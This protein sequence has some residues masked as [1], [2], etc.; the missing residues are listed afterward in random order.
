M[1]KYL[2]YS[3]PAEHFEQALPL[4]N[5]T[6]GAMVY[7]RWDTEKIS[8]NHDTLWSGKPRRYTRPDAAKAYAE[9]QK[10]VL[11]GKC[12]QA[13]ELLERDFT[14]NFGE[15]YLPLGDLLISR[16]GAT[17]PVS[18]RRTL[19]MEHGVVSVYYT[20]GAGSVES[21]YFVSYTDHCLV[22]RFACEV[23]SSFRISLHCQLQY[24]VRAE[25]D[26]LVLLGEC[27]SSIA[28][29]YAR[30]LVETVYNGEGIRFAAV[31]CAETDGILCA[32]G[33]SL[34]V[35]NATALCLRL[36]AETSYLSFDTPPTKEYEV[37]CRARAEALSAHSYE[38]LR[39]RHTACFSDYYNR[40]KLELGFAE[41][42]MMTDERLIHFSETKDLGLVELL[43]HFG[44]YLM[45][46]SHGTDSQASNLQ[47]IWNESVFPP[48]SSNYTVNINTEM[49]YWP[50]LMCG[51]AG[52][53]MPLIGLLKKI[54]VTG[55]D[56][57]RNFYGAKGYCAH[58]NVDLW[59]LAT[60]VGA[61]RKGCLEYA[62]WCMSS[63]WLCRHAWEH[64]EYTLDHEYLRETAYPLMKG[65]AEFYLSVMIEDGG[66]YI[67]CPSTSP[68]NKY[69]DENHEKVA[70]ARYT[71]MT[72]AIV[73]D[74]FTNLSRAA[75]VLG[76]ED[77]FIDEI[78]EKL[79]LLNT[80]AVGT[81]GQLLE[82]DREYEEVDIHHR[83][84][85]HLYGLYPGE[86]ITTEAT[87][88]LAEACKRTL[89]RRGDASTGWSMGW[90]V[91]LWAK[92]KD[93]DHALELVKRQLSYVPPTERRS[94]RGGGSYPN[95]FDA[96]PPFQIDG[97]F[98][99]CAGIAQ[100]LLQCEDGK[101]RIL[102]ALPAAFA[103]GT[104]CGMK[105]KGNITVDISWKDGKLVSCAL[106]TPY[107][108]TVTVVT[109]KGERV[110]ALI[111]NEK[112]MI[113]E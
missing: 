28:P 17:E 60:P 71:T 59:G 79:P 106:E 105:A 40:V 87:P 49:N 65:A 104:L 29:A 4:G 9:A 68:E 35:Q 75:D 111:P 43:F 31:A 51:Y 61:Q 42:Q 63:G 113:T 8:L 14:A 83:H 100:M 82:Y 53:D 44:R 86:S 110:L 1:E 26:R 70:L 12:L 30:E 33:D 80:Y 52:M 21:E 46:A 38:T 41:S 88:A 24:T 72:Q 22:V 5:G 90:K 37:P 66:H 69:Y 20:D 76:I 73:M 78:R 6:L 84:V 3:A 93:G 98:G 101:L 58:H 64:Y 27:P 109:P 23:P 48:W 85:S 99:V 107:A 108:Q 7:G 50:V 56:V 39:Q 62:Y 91:N 36:C 19:D 96:H 32:E 15:S 74:L 54:S 95:L 45:I 102:P 10:L 16:I 112:M 13:T 77:A 92:L 57:A 18:Y 11:E 67:I 94:W 103:N 97:N 34:T 89:I 55:R 47:G 2:R 25:G 81:D